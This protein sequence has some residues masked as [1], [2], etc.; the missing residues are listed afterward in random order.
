[1]GA[2]EAGADLAALAAIIA[3]IARRTAPDRDN[4]PGR[5]GGVSLETTLDGAGLHPQ[6]Q[7][8]AL[9]GHQQPAILIPARHRPAP[10]RIGIRAL[11]P[12]GLSLHR[13]LQ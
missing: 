5:G 2:A 10:V 11:A 8:P 12:G 3:E 13:T 1:V 7:P 4:D 9:T 6:P